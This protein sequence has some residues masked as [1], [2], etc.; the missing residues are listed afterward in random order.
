M[1][2]YNY[3]RFSQSKQFPGGA[4]VDLQGTKSNN[5]MERVGA[6]LLLKMLKDL[7]KNKTHYN[8]NIFP[9]FFKNSSVLQAHAEFKVLV[10]NHV[11]VWPDQ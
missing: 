1:Q 10:D 5:Y 2:E 11:S 4:I 9:W 6:A 3:R 8:V 7:I